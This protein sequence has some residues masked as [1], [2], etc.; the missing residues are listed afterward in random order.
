MPFARK[1]VCGA[2]STDPVRLYRQVFLQHD[3]ECLP[4]EAED[5]SPAKNGSLTSEFM[6]HFSSFIFRKPGQAMYQVTIVSPQWLALT[7]HIV[8]GELLHSPHTWESLYL[9]TLGRCIF[10]PTSDTSQDTSNHYCPPRTLWV[11]CLWGTIS[12]LHQKSPP[13]PRVPCGSGEKRKI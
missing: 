1:P 7:W 4:M 5:F 13:Q 6:W 12:L 10:F 11:S 9:L 8:A 3:M 2:I